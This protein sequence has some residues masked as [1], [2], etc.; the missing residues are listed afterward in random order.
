MFR[1]IRP[2]ARPSCENDGRKRPSFLAAAA[3][4]ARVSLY[5][6]M[7]DR[8]LTEAADVSE[9]AIPPDAVARR[10][11]LPGRRASRGR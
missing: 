3:A 7:A 2:G 9:R 8:G 1:G 10:E 5:T 4:R 11:P 6:V